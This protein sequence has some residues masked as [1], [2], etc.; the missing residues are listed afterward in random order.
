LPQPPSP[1]DASDRILSGVIDPARILV[2]GYRHLGDSL[3]LTPMLRALKRRFPD[4]AIDVTAGGAGAAALEGK[5]P[6][7]RVGP[8][9][10]RGARPKL[11]LVP[12]LRRERF[13]VGVMAQHSLPNA[14]YLR[15]VG[16]STTVGLAAYG[17]RPFLTHGVPVPRLRDTWHEA[18]RYLGLAAALGAPGDDA[19]LEFH[20]AAAD[21]AEAAATLARLGLA[22]RISAPHAGRP[23]IVALFPGSSPEWAFK[24]WPADRFA[25]LGRKLVADRLATVLVVGGPDD[26]PVMRDV[27]AAIGA[28]HAIDDTPGQLGR[29]A[30]L[31]AECD[32]LVTNDSGPM[33][34]ATAV[35]T[36]VVDLAGPSDPRRT[37]P[38]GRGHVVIQ[39]VPPGRPR[40]WATAPDPTLPMKLITVEE[41]D[42]AVR[43]MLT[44]P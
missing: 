2:L 43:A 3:F 18:D 20:V 15:L 28:P 17:C 29:F 33:H 4:A 23:P 16:C 19:G 40:Q 27:S 11:A 42:A 7:A 24:R 21:R 8:L 9:R 10:G 36:R 13:D 6:G 34:L 35:G 32:V 12:K 25:T 44:S 38:Y 37:G 41:V 30:A 26:L 5:P 22:G 39:K 14:L 31:V 1:A